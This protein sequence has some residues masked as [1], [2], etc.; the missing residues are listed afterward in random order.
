MKKILA[1]VACVMLV[2]SVQSQDFPAGEQ[3]WH[4]QHHLMKDGMAK[5]KLTGSEATRL[6]KEYHQV[7]KEERRMKIS[8]RL[9]ER[10]YDKRY[11]KHHPVAK[12]LVHHRE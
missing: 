8:S 10:A 12:S 4:H 7:R 3:K 5:G 9:T 1:L 6:R 2:G 11:G